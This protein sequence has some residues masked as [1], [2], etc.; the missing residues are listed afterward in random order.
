MR[1]EIVNGRA[2][3]AGISKAAGAVRDGAADGIRKAT[4]DLAEDVARHTP[5]KSGKARDSVIGRT[6]PK[7]TVGRVTYSFKKRGAYYMRVILLGTY[8][9]PHGYPIKLKFKTKKGLALAQR[10]A[11]RKAGRLGR[12]VAAKLTRKKALKIPVGGGFIFRASVLRHPGVKGRNILQQRLTANQQKIFN[13]IQNSVARR[14]G[15]TFG[16]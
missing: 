12:K 11:D 14:V 6:S 3:I 9:K 1:V 16:R 10:A 15:G 2:V 13:T 8:K 5:V 7:G 4:T